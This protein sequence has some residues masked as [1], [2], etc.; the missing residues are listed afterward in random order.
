MMMMEMAALIGNRKQ[1]QQRRHTSCPPPSPWGGV[2]DYLDG[3]G[4]GL[5]AFFGVAT[6]RVL[7]MGL[8]LLPPPRLP[9]LLLTPLL[10]PLLLLLLLSISR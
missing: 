10:L 8:V 1:W 3:F 9:L 5:G 6:P 2:G 4:R 7:K